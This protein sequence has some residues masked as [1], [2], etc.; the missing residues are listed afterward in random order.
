M[1]EKSYEIYAL[2]VSNNGNDANPGTIEEPFATL[3]RA[4]LAVR[5]V[6]HKVSG[7]HTVFVRE[8]TYYFDSTLTFEPEDSGYEGAVIIRGKRWY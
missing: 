2:Y 5:Q 6:K 3:E 4:K 8:G 1:E 7:Q